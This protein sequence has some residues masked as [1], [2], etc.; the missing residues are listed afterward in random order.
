ML[1]DIREFGGIQGE[2]ISLARLPIPLP[3]H[4]VSG[5]CMEA[6]ALKHDLKSA[7]VRPPPP[8]T[9]IEQWLQTDP[10]SLQS[11]SVAQGTTIA[12]G[13]SHFAFSILNPSQDH[14]SICIA[15][16][17]RAQH[18]QTWLA[19]PRHRPQHWHVTKEEA[20]HLNLGQIKKMDRISMVK[21]GQETIT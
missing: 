4:F 6:V 16:N 8:T 19:P 17:S 15:G 3:F 18:R 5:L 2:H 12:N 20:V 13:V 14:Y 7:A 1:K 11:A 21:I 9:T 10:H